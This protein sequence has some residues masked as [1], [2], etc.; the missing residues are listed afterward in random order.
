VAY[1]DR[2]GGAKTARPK[3]RATQ[4]R[5]AR[6]AT[7]R[8]SVPPPRPPAPLGAIPKLGRYPGAQQAVRD[9]KRVAKTQPQRPTPYVPVIRHPTRQQTAAAKQ[10]IIREVN[11]RV[12]THGTGAERN[13]RRKQVLQQIHD[14]PRQ[15]RFKAAI[16]H[17]AAKDEQQTA[18]LLGQHLGAKG[19]RQQI[20]AGRALAQYQRQ[21]DIVRPGRGPKVLTAGPASINLGGITTAKRAILGATSLGQGDIGPRHFAEN[22]FKDVGALGALPFVGGYTALHGS[23][24]AAHGHP[25]ELTNLVKGVAQGFYDSTP[26]Y[27]ARAGANAAH[28]NLHGAQ[29]DLVKAGEAVVKHPVFEALNTA[30]AVS[31]LGRTS[32]ALVRAIGSH[33]EAPGVRGAFARAG[34]TVLQPVALTHDASAVRNGAY[35]QRTASKDLTRSGAQR[36]RDAG[37]EVLRDQEGKPVTVQDRGRTVT[38]LKPTDRELRTL[39]HRRADFD[40]SRTQARSRAER[41]GVDREMNRADASVSTRRG[42]AADAAKRWVKPKGRSAIEDRLTHLVATGTVRTADSL[43]HDL[44]KRAQQIRS[45]LEQDANLPMG[46]KL[47]HTAD[48]RKVAEANAKWME[49]VARHPKTAQHAQRIVERGLA[50]ARLLNEADRGVAA[51][52]VG[53]EQML[54]R[55]ALSEYALAH[56]DARHVTAEEHARLERDASTPEEAAAVSGRDPARLAAHQEAV[57]RHGHAVA[58]HKAVQASIARLERTRARLI[59]AQSVRR[60]RDRRANTPA[61]IRK[62]KNVERL[63]RNARQQERDLRTERSITKR[64]IAKNPM[65]ERHAGLRHPDGTYLS[66]EDIRAHALASGRDPETLAYLPHRMEAELKGSH[67]TQNRPG[68]RPNFDKGETR[69]GELYRRGA[70]AFGRD[71]VHDE[72]T[73]K[74]TQVVKADSV[75]R[76]VA[77]VGMRHPAWAKAER[78]EDLTPAEQRIVSKGGLFTAKEAAEYA[79]RIEGNGGERLV[80]ITVHPAS[81]R[82]DAAEALRGDISPAAM[83]T[84]DANMLSARMNPTGNA[85]NVVLM[86]GHYID[87]QLKHLQPAGE[88]FKGFQI[89]NAPFRMAVLPQPRWL[90]GNFFE[91]YVVRLTLSGAGLNLPGMAVDVA[92]G[93][94]IIREMRRSGDPKVRAQAENIMAQQ[95]GGLFVGRRGASVRRTFEDFENPAV[96]KALYG[97]HVVRNLPV[98]KQMGDL[99]LAFPKSFFLLN[100]VVEEVP[101]LASLGKSTRNDIQ[102]F[103]GSWAKSVTLG[104]KALEDAA[105]GLVDTPTQQRF[106]REQ[107]ILLGKYEGFPPWLRQLIQGPTPFLPWV[108]ASMRFIYWTL[109]TSHT[110]AEAALVMGGRVVQDQWDQAHAA[111]GAIP[112]SALNYAQITK[113][114]G[115]VDFARYTPFGASIP[116][117]EGDF[118]ALL[119]VF[120]PQVQGAEAALQGQDPFGRALQVRPSPSNP[121]GQVTAGG[122]KAKIALNQLLGGLV[123][124]WST[125]QRLREKGGTGYADSNPLSP[126]VKPGSSHMSALRRTYDPFRPTYLKGG[127]GGGGSNAGGG[128]GGGA[129]VDAPSQQEIQDAIGQATQLDPSD[130]EDIRRAVSGR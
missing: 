2:P 47:Y 107:H 56:M 91:P 4:V 68:N 121:R 21:R 52:H 33:P 112:G 27:I 63:L 55:S 105:R 73:R 37:R 19:K 102:A 40:A 48:E 41:A 1:G 51:R 92:A 5:Q 117:S 84:L 17:Y 12:G 53:S 88:I 69:T 20:A 54:Q 115:F 13:A 130:L 98:L 46:E 35:H 118:R 95:R 3:S 119:D 89:L 128:G 86:P 44:E 129:S 126:K 79:R 101:Q 109:P 43:V 11:R 87:R 99:I 45:S 103:T 23:W 38:V 123:P 32:G 122:E 127:G 111:A 15:A 120:L 24:S 49:D 7:R 81:M 113:K 90:T 110:V 82:G 106:M 58:R 29:S 71:V 72:L 10:L 26:G 14:D 65:P 64:R 59:G 66:N 57:A 75:D 28:G 18:Q 36:A 85:R 60:G 9:R 83:E 100:R 70:V 39:G 77:D 42:A 25:Q 78:G 114:G 80:P 16:D 125:V 124:W 93:A 67:Y 61:E 50:H 34:D 22:A 97:A 74:A 96:R 31:A 108:M 8:P 116:L 30:G 6:K 104:K 62:L 94:K 76:M